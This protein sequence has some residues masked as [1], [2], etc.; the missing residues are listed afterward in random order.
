MKWQRGDLGRF[1][2]ES[3]KQPRF[4]VLGRKDDSILV[5]YGGK[6]T[7]DAIPVATFKK[8]CTNLWEIQEIVPARPVWLK[9]GAEF[10]LPGQVAARQAEIRDLKYHRLVNTS[11]VLVGGQPLRIRYIRRDYAS[12]MMGDLLV[13]IPLPLIVKSGIQRTTRWSRLMSDED[14]FE[15]DPRDE[16]LFKDF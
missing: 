8:D 2:S 11:N 6:A 10:E 16:D 12:C 1:V 3:P 14:P 7:Q 13:L 15:D 4:E 9:E 5:W